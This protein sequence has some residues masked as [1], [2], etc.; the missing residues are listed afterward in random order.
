[1]DL[2]QVAVDAVPVTTAD[3]L[4]VAVRLVVAANTQASLP[5]AALAEARSLC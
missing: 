2:D 3:E 4:D 1:V 5:Q